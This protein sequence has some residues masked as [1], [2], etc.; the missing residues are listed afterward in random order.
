MRCMV[1]DISIKDCNVTLP[2]GI[3]RVHESFGDFEK[4]ICA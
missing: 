4:D 1:F 3:L 2:K